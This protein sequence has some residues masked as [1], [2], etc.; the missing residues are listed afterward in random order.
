VHSL[1]EKGV[2]IE[3]P[4]S[5]FVSPTCQVAPGAHLGPQVQLLGNTKIG[6]GVKIEGNAYLTN[7]TVLDSALIRFGVRAENAIIGE[8]AK[9]GPFAHLRPG[10][11]LSS[12]VHIG[13]FVETKNATIQEGAKANHLSY[14]GDCHIGTNSN[15]GAGTITCNYDGYRKSHTEIG[16]SVFVGSNT[17]LVAPVTIEDGATIAAGSVITKRVEKDSLAIT[18]A[19]QVSKSGWSKRKRDVESKR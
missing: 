15:I 18:R 6:A 17:S 10:T 19:E 11:Q 16:N 3:D 14:L 9:V 7:T 13:N 5:C 8:G 2:I 4:A 1:I 12:N